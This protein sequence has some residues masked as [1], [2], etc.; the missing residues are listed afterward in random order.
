MYTKMC[1]LK[2]QQKKKENNIMFIKDEGVLV[3]IE[4]KN[5][6][7]ICPSSNNYAR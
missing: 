1:F 7:A 4:E 5:F 3:T 6:L 2:P